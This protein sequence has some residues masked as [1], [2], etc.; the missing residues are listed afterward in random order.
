M[1]KITSHNGPQGSF[2]RGSREPVQVVR[3][4]TR[5]IGERIGADRNGTL[6]KSSGPGAEDWFQFSLALLQGLC[7]WVRRVAS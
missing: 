2:E 6:P 7:L 3:Y 5:R 1:L 4:N